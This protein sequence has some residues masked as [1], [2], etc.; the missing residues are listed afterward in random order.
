MFFEVFFN[1]PGEM[2]F[3]FVFYPKLRESRKAWFLA[4]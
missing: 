2:V 4:N 1:K 3:I